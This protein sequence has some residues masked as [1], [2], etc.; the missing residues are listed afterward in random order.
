MA[1]L[2]PLNAEETREYMEHRLRVADYKSSRRLFT[3]AACELIAEYSGGI[4]RNINNYCFNA[5]SLGYALKQSTIGREIV[6]E[7]FQDLHLAD[8]S[9]NV[10][11]QSGPRTIIPQVGFAPLMVAPPASSGN[12]LRLTAVT[13]SIAAVLCVA[14]VLANERLN[15]T[16]HL[17]FAVPAPPPPVAAIDTSVP[18]ATADTQA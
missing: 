6:G 15:S 13:F 16:S 2:R 14:G 12:G 11:K 18:V 17:N 5:L 8:T 4:P 7:V 9:A 10:S 1:V 3:P